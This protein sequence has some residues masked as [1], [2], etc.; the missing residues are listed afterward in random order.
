MVFRSRVLDA[1]RLPRLQLR[2]PGLVVQTLPTGLRVLDESRVSQP[3]GG[4]KVRNLEWL[5]G[6]ARAGG[7][8]VVTLGPAGGQHLLASAVYGQRAGLRVHAVAWPQPWSE[9]AERSLRVLHAHAE[10][11]WPAA[12]RNLSPFTVGRVVATVR[13]L[14]GYPP[15]LWPPGGSSPTGTLGWVQ[16]GLD[17]AAAIQT[18]ELS[19]IERVYVPLGS[20]GLAAGLRAG[21]A[22]GGSSATVV[23]VDVTGG[24]RLAVEAVGFGVKRLLARHGVAVG[25]LAPL[26]IVREAS[27]YGVPTQAGTAASQV[28]VDAGAFVDSTYGAKALA[29]ALRDASPRKCLFVATANARPLDELLTGALTNLPQRLRRLLL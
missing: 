4:S 29:V 2:E 21:L 19:G 18:G 15:T 5:L 17:I 9:A 23:A 16:G 26:Q 11:V 1:L 28:A 25:K 14:A 27:A 24:G 3:L 20:G 10:V 8:D 12:S 7:G 13:F 6:E 22:L